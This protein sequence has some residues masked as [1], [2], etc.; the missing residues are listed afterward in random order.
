MEKGI[1]GLKHV[2]HEEIIE[3][4]P[5]LELYSYRKNLNVIECENLV[6]AEGG[7]GCNFLAL[8]LSGEDPFEY[9]MGKNEFQCNDI[10]AISHYGYDHD[11][12]AFQLDFI[13]NEKK[14]ASWNEHILFFLDKIKYRIETLGNLK[15]KTIKDHFIPTFSLMFGDVVVNKSLVI[16]LNSESA[17]F[18]LLLLRIKHDTISIIESKD[19]VRIRIFNILLS[20]KNDANITNFSSMPELTNMYWK[21]VRGLDDTDCKWIDRDSPAFYSIMIRNIPET[22]EQDDN[23]HFLSA[24]NDQWSKIFKEC[25]WGL[26]RTPN[27]KFYDFSKMLL[28]SSSDECDI[29]TYEDF[30]FR[31]KTPEY[32]TDIQKEYIKRYTS[33]NLDIVYSF[34]KW[35]QET[36]GLNESQQR[37][38][39][40]LKSW[41]MEFDA[42]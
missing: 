2:N 21:T 15:Y 29:I 27:D 6:I 13:I 10:P 41:K 18:I 4:F 42:L 30:F 11:H 7:A 36:N 38:F 39:D 25:T 33:E 40:Q 19:D 16:D 9:K 26:D 3:Y 32:I 12:V 28:K 37:L 20:V 5:A 34:F 17:W 35:Q 31:L 22:Y 23:P 8:L 14:R 1:M 24:L